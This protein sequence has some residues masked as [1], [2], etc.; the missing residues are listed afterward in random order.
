MQVVGGSTQKPNTE[1]KQ[2]RAIESGQVLGQFVQAAPITAAVTLRMFQR[3]FDDVEISRDE[4]KAIM[5]GV[6]QVTGPTPDPNARGDGT[7]VPNQGQ[8]GQQG[9]PMQLLAILD[10]SPPQVKQAVFGAVMQGVPIAEAVS[11][12]LQRLQGGAPQPGATSAAP[13]QNQPAPSTIQ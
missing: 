12:V 6:Q 4:W 2:K 11:G 8:F 13:P 10:Q 1:A 5:D 9:D 7:A 3:A